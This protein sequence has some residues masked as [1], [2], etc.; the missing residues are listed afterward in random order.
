VTMKSRECG[1]A[2]SALAVASY[3]QF[4][5]MFRSCQ[6]LRGRQSSRRKCVFVQKREESRESEARSKVS[7][8]SCQHSGGGGPW[9][10]QR[11]A[12]FRHLMSTDQRYQRPRNTAGRDGK[13]LEIVR[14]SRTHV[15][16]VVS[17][18]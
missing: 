8:I 7:L 17:R 15:V 18:R 3:G 9:I 6:Q 16:S 12:N 14:K 5:K 10:T 2:M 1:G 11:R 4:G 13:Y